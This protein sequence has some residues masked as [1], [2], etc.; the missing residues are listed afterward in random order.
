MKPLRFFALFFAL[1]AFIT[2]AAKENY[3]V[4]LLG[5]LHYDGAHLRIDRDNLPQKSAGS[6]NR[7]LKHWQYIPAMLL[8][9]LSM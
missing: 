9:L 1:L 2:A 4:V 6:L 8:T 3:Q 5:D 7:N